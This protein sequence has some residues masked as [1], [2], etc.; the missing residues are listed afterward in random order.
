VRLNEFNQIDE[1]ATEDHRVEVDAYLQR[2]GFEKIGAGMDAMVYSKDS[3]T[4]TK[5]IFPTEVADMNLSVKTF[6]MFYNFCKRARSLYLPAF[7]EVKELEIAGEKFQAVIMERLYPIPEASYEEA[8]V[9]LL[10]ECAQ[11]KMP[12]EQ[13]YEYTQEPD[14]WRYY[15]GAYDL[16]QIVYEPPR[17]SEWRGFYEAMVK[18]FNALPSKR[19]WDLHTENVMMRADGTPIIVDPWVH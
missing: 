3:N 17:E 11:K 1:Y 15:D 4:V 14:A 5:I 18:T 12:W 13:V 19:Y 8:I 10:G 2:A 9:W 16:N 6:K 7:S